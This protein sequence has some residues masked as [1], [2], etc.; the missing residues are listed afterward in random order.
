MF[1]VCSITFLSHGMCFG[2]K[3]HIAAVWAVSSL[4]RNLSSIPIRESVSFI[5]AGHD[6][7]LVIQFSSEDITSLLHVISLHILTQFFIAF[8]VPVNNNGVSPSSSNTPTLVV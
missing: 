8:L 7:L 2:E 5:P 1:P 6:K 3:C 4:F